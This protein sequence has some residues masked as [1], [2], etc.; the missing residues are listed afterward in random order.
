MCKLCKLGKVETYEKQF[1]AQKKS[2]FKTQY[3]LTFC[4]YSKKKKK[5]TV[6]SGNIA[7]SFMLLLSE[8]VL[9]YP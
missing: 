9:L 7:R 5:I 4:L 3:G 8:T 2:M 1:Q 6:E